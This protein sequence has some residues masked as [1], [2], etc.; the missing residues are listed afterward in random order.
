MITE[1]FD[2]QYF[3][4]TFWDRFVASS[5]ICRKI[6][7]RRS[8]RYDR[9]FQNAED[10]LTRELD[11]IEVLNTLRVSKMIAKANSTP[12]HRELVKFFDEYC[13]SSGVSG[14]DIKLDQTLVEEQDA[15]IKF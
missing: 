7:C 8:S 15:S 2:R 11:I 3:K 10:K 4:Y 13:L 12:K 14:D 5:W 9:L 6:L 1:L